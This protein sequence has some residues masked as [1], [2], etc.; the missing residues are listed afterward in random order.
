MRIE[1]FNEFTH[2]LDIIN[3]YVKSQDSTWYTTPKGDIVLEFPQYDM[4]PQ[5]YSAPWNNILQ[6]Q[7]EFS[8]FSSTEDDRNLMT[9][10]IVSGS[11]VA[12]IDA[13][14]AVPF[15]AFARHFNPSLA[16]RF[17]IREQRQG[18]PFKYQLGVAHG[19]LPALASL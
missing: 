10:T 19:S 8:K 5:K 13:Q 6:I 17:G 16:A 3:E 18:R 12:S 9:F 15:M 4:L 14:K 1:H 7:N 2:R 11:A